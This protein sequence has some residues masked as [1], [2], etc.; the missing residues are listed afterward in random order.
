MKKED[1]LDDDCDAEE[2]ELMDTELETISQRNDTN[3]KR[4]LEARRRIEMLC[5]L[6]RLK[7][8]CD[9]INLDDL[10]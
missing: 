1:L 10:Y 6:R 8:E 3:A 9:D 7:N 4:S 5:E 2:D